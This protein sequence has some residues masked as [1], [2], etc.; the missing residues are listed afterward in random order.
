MDAGWSD[1]G[2]WSSLW[3]LSEKDYNGNA[4]HGDVVLYKSSNS[5]VR[6]DG[7]LVTAIGVMI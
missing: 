3:D 5:Y 1:I 2:S 4:I 6:S 7:M